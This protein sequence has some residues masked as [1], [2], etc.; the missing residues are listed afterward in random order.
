MKIAAITL[1]VSATSLLKKY[2]KRAQEKTTPCSILWSL[3][4]QLVDSIVYP[5]TA[6]E[7]LPIELLDEYWEITIIKANNSSALF[8]VLV[9]FRSRIGEIM[10]DD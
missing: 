3:Q 6:R 9:K 2:Q 8:A 10:A 7:C 5:I 1:S 4:S